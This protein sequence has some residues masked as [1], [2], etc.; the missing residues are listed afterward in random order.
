MTCLD[1]H[2]I[3]LPCQGFNL[4]NGKNP[5]S[6]KKLCIANYGFL[7]RRAMFLPLSYQLPKVV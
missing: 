7:A 5:A 6:L 3:P 2:K 4:F 1:F